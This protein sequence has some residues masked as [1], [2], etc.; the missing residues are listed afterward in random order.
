MKNVSIYF[1]S[2]VVVILFSAVPNLST[3]QE[4][5]GLLI[6]EETFEEELADWY[7]V[8]QRDIESQDF[9]EDGKEG[10]GITFFL[11]FLPDD[12][13]LN[14][15]Q[16]TF[17]GLETPPEATLYDWRVTF[18]IRTR[19]IPFTIRPIVAMSEDPWTGSAVE[20][21]IET[22]E[23]WVFVDTV[24]P[25]GDFLTTD[26]FLLIFHMGNP[27]DESGENEVSFDEIKLFLLN[28]PTS[29][30]EWSLF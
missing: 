16:F 14:N 6:F 23:E 3:A 22:A 8:Q 20:I 15:L 19:V 11:S 2:F 12:A 17:E 28:E 10:L 24:L 4:D 5:S 25:V 30:D 27:G 1:I 9:I 29:V 18:W 21:P 13:S 7:L 26:T